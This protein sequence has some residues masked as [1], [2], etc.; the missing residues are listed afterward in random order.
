MPSPLNHMRGSE[1]Q[2]GAW[3]PVSPKLHLVPSSSGLPALV[4]HRRRLRVGTIVVAEPLPG[5]AGQLPRL[6]QCIPVGYVIRCEDFVASLDK[7]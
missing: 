2:E 6:S 1:E 4:L 5:E 7:S 3:W